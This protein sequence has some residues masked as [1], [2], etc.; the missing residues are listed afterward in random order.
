MQSCFEQF[1]RLHP[2][3]KLVV[4][5]C[6]VSYALNRRQSRSVIVKEVLKEEMTVSTY[7]SLDGINNKIKW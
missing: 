3:T 6:V 2:L 7:N 5:D 4:M 1:V